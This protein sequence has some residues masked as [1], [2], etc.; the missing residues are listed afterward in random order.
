MLGWLVSKLHAEKRHCELLQLEGP[1]P[2]CS[3]S[4]WQLSGKIAAAHLD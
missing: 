4:V 1:Q 3:I 2:N